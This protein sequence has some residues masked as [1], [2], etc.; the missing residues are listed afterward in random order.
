MPRHGPFVPR[1]DAD[2]MAATG[3][4]GGVITF[5]K[6]ADEFHDQWDGKSSIK[7]KIDFRKAQL[8]DTALSAIN[9]DAV[10]RVEWPR[11]MLGYL[12]ASRLVVPGSGHG[13]G[14]TDSCT[15]AIACGFLR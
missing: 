12:P 14:T 5:F 1:G 11:E 8:G 3:I 6:L 4:K 13:V 2:L 15:I 9:A 10:T 7:G